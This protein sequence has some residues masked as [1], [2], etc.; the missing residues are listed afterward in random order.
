MVNT[1]WLDR[2]VCQIVEF[3]LQR[4]YSYL[5]LKMFR[6]SEI[7]VNHISKLIVLKSSL[8]TYIV[9]WFFT[10]IF[11]FFVI[12]SCSRRGVICSSCCGGGGCVISCSSCCRSG[13]GVGSS[14]SSGSCSCG[15]V[16]SCVLRV[17][18]L[19]WSSWW[20][21]LDCGLVRESWLDGYMWIWW[22]IARWFPFC[23][24]WWGKLN[25][26]IWDNRSCFINWRWFDT[27]RLI[28]EN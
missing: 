13:R 6:I 23:V 17:V 19:V 4:K 5:V 24:D 1:L 22:N 16:I 7:F 28:R 10:W 12:S 3:N 27:W 26:M 18:W 2:G 14:C 8:L 11:I 21:K 20:L 9:M 25:G 15:G